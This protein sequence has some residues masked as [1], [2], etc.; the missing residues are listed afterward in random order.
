MCRLFLVIY[1]DWSE[2]VL[3]SWPK[4]SEHLNGSGYWIVF[5]VL[6]CIWHQ[7]NSWVTVAPEQWNGDAHK[8]FFHPQDSM[9]FLII[10]NVSWHNEIESSPLL[11]P[12]LHCTCK[13]P[14]SLS[15]EDMHLAHFITPDFL[16][17]YDLFYLGGSFHTD[18]VTNHRHKPFNTG[19]GDG[20]PNGHWCSLVGQSVH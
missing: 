1:T 7:R 5:I 3:I 4:W 13:A 10:L 19:K 6:N 11:I 8:L 12:A 16:Q 14:E 17:C 18:K 2:I 15:S 20:F 9:Y